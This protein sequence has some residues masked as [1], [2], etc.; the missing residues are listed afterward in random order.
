MIPEEVSDLNMP[1]E[2]IWGWGGVGGEKDPVSWV[3]LNKMGTNEDKHGLAGVWQ[4]FRTR[5]P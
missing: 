4:D 2:E 5:N 1:R 3:G